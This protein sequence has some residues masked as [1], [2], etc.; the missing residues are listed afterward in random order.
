M[1]ASWLRWVVPAILL[2]ALVAVPAGAQDEPPSFKEMAASQNNLKQIVL[3][4]HNFHDANDKFIDDIRDKDGK[5]LLSWRVALLPYIEENPLYESFKLDEPWDSDTNKKLIAKMPK[6]Y[7]PIRVKAKPGETFYQ[8][9]TG[10][11]TLFGEKGPLYKLTNIPDGSS[12]TALVV[13]AGA[14]VIWSKPADIAFDEKK[15][16][17]KLGGMFDGLLHTA[18]CDGSVRR[19]RADFDADEMKK[20]IMP[21]DGAKVDFKKLSK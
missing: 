9:F 10:K 11:G 1:R 4:V 12:S 5:P 19:V 2:G 15:P 7:A 17:P 6:I 8:T 14:P 21:A 13:E 16:L 20:F 3:A 18:L